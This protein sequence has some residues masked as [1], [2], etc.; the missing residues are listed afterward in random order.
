LIVIVALLHASS[1]INT[2]EDPVEKVDEQRLNP[3]HRNIG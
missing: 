1:M 2:V 3:V